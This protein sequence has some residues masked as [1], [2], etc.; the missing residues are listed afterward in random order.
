MATIISK[1]SPGWHFRPV[2]GDLASVEAMLLPLTNTPRDYAWGSTTAIAQLRGLVPSGRPEAELW[3]GAHSA[4]P[5]VVTDGSPIPLDAWIASNPKRALVGATKLPFLLKLLAAAAP[6]SLQAH[7]SRAQAQAGFARE[8]AAGL[9][10]DSPVRNYRD[11]EHKPELI[12]ALSDE[13]IALSGFRPLAQSLHDLQAI[14][15]SGPDRELN[16]FVDELRDRALGSARSA[17]SWAVEHVLRGGEPARKLA[18]ALAEAAASDNALTHA[19][20]A[21]ATI[22][23]LS[24]QYPGDPGVVIGSLLNRVVL[25]RGEALFLPAGNLHAYLSGFGVEL[26][27][28]SDNVLRGGLTT[29][30]VDVDELIRVADF[31]PLTDPRLTPRVLDER[32]RVFETNV[33]DFVLFHFQSSSTQEHSQVPVVVAAIAVCVAGEVTLR[34][35][36]EEL[37]VTRGEACFVTGDETSLNIS[38][39]GEIFVASSRG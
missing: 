12:V 36:H 32:L 23:A 14:A 35:R 28:A 25:D 8:N 34:G 37:T 4:S 6:L 9:S 21:T 11:D 26:M 16:E 19:P 29:K 3:L 31:E 1:F 39:A 30:H 7:P 15:D 13:F 24:A 22:R 33:D 10:L 17:L 27:S 20:A 5:A 38:G 18:L 2:R